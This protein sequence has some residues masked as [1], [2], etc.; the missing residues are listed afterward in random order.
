MEG[1]RG[2]S[3]TGFVCFGFFCQKCQVFLGKL[4]WEED[5]KT[6]FEGKANIVSKENSFSAK[7]NFNG[8]STPSPLP[9]RLVAFRC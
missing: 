4:L 9:A 8:K 3:G 7:K 2:R 6:I 1:G 5:K